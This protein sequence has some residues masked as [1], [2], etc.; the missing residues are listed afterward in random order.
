ME[1]NKPDLVIY[2]KI[3]PHV[4]QERVQKRGAP[5][6][7]F[8]KERELFI[9]TLSKG[10]DSLFEHRSE[11]ITIDGTQDQTT[12]STQATNSIL[13]WLNDKQIT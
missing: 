3:P 1:N 7:S 11:V 13:H 12:L 6:S 10:F 9:Q 8:E 5:L 2:V 4:A